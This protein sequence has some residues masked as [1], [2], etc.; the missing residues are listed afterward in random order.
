MCESCPMLGS[1]K[2]EKKKKK[3]E[4]H[5]VFVG[6]VTQ[7]CSPSNVC[8]CVCVWSVDTRVHT[9]SSLSVFMMLGTAS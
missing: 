8:V 1:H 7:L 4:V 5:S 2:N 6:F 9:Q 3:K